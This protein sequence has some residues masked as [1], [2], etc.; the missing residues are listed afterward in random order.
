[1]QFNAGHGLNYRNVGPIA[2]LERIAELHIGH[3]IVSRAIF[4]GIRAAVQ[5][6][7]ALITAPLAPFTSAH[8]AHEEHDECDGGEDCNC[9]AHAEPD[10]R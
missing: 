4:V 7:K 2:E 5:E 8:A 6:M 3:A 10:K 9:D 1:M